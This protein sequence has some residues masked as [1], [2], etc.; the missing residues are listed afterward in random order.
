MSKLRIKEIVCVAA[1]LLFI[2]LL[3]TQNKQSAADPQQVFDDVCAAIDVSA[4]EE[5]REDQ[6]KKAFGFDAS[7]FEFV[8]YLASSD[9]MEV[10]EVLL[11]KL[12]AGTDEEPLLNKIRTRVEDKAEL[13]AGYAPEQSGYLE[14][15]ALRA[16]SGY[17]LYVVSEAPDAAVRAFKKAL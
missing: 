4:L 6:F 15:F 1:L 7:D 8:G 11:V 2:V 5:R 17:V 9:V 12:P 16:R 13:F 3:T 14:T 10:R